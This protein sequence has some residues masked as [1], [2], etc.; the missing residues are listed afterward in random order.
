ML[1]QQKYDIGYSFDLILEN[2][3]SGLRTEVGNM[4][5]IINKNKI[6]IKIPYIY[7]PITFME[8]V[9]DEEFT[10]L[11]SKMFIDKPNKD[12]P[13]IVYCFT[14][15]DRWNLFYSITQSFLKNDFYVNKIELSHPAGFHKDIIFSRV[16]PTIRLPKQK[17][18]VT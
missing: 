15:K 8:N 17:Q 2:P 10:F 4:N 18:T 11:R 6:D 5:Y 9:N 3:I 16:V 12:T 14:S 7:N 1:K 13:Y